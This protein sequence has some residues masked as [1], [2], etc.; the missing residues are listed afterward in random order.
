MIHIDR[1]PTPPEI[2]FSSEAQRAFDEAKE[3]YSIP[4]EKRIQRSWK[5]N[6]LIWTD[7][8]VVRTIQEVFHNKCAFCEIPITSKPVIEHFRPMGGA[9]GLDGS[10]DP[11]HYWW[12]AYQWEN[13]YLIC[14]RCSFNKG[15]KFPVAG[16]RPKIQFLDFQL[17]Q[18][19]L[20]G[21]IYYKELSKERA[22]LVDPCL[23][24]EF[25]EKMFLFTDDGTLLGTD[26][27]GRGQQTIEIFG[28]NRDELLRDRTKAINNLRSILDRALG[29]A[30]L[31]NIQSNL[32]VKSSPSGDPY[33]A[34]HEQLSPE[35]PYLG[36]KRQFI[37]RWLQSDPGRYI[38][39][40]LREVLGQYYDLTQ[41]VQPYQSYE[42]NAIKSKYIEQKLKTETEKEHITIGKAR[43]IKR[44]EIRNFRALKSLELDFP[45]PR[46]D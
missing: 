25:P 43:Y 32:P 29:A 20:P 45:E 16:K 46:T 21:D 27:Q 13:L 30:E 4:L 44:I 9:I 19:P 35:A 2:F 31:P 12:L 23:D 37:S 15:K 34:L 28:L 38:D 6:S 33:L 11:D 14:E 10:H 17:Y 42:Q 18:K 26:K 41:E 24:H 7:P 39:P 3:F 8:A 36:A 22:L 40:Q 5:F 1:M